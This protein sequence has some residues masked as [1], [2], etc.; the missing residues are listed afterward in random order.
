VF[1]L[2]HHVLKA[3]VSPNPHHE[4]PYVYIVTFFFFSSLLQVLFLINEYSL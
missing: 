1:F 2:L 3:C 4:Q